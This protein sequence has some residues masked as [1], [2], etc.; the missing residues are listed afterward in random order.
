VRIDQ[1]VLVEQDSR[2]VW[3]APPDA[4]AIEHE[5][6]RLAL[7][8]YRRRSAATVAVELGAIIVLVPV[9]AV[10]PDHGPVFGAVATLF[11]LVVIGL[12]PMCGGLVALVNSR[13]IG[14]AL[15]RH[16]WVSW[17]AQYR[18]IPW[19]TDNAAGILFLGADQKQ[20]MDV[21]AYA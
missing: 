18:M 7:R 10:I 20:V 16:P 12:I 9:L 4:P 11:V 5:A 13:R 1:Y 21:R 6:T 15:R 19:G 3:N 17:P 8:S 2:P 14:S